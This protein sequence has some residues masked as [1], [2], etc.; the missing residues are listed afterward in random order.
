[1]ALGIKSFLRFSYRLLFDT[2]H[3]RLGWTCRR[4]AVIVGFYLLFPLLELAI[5]LGLLLD[6][7]LFREYQQEPIESPVFIVGNPRSGTTLLHRLLTKDV[8]RFSTMRMWEILLSPSVL[9]RRVVGAFAALD[10]RLGGPLKKRV[11]AL[12]EGWQQQNL[13]HR[14]S[15]WAPEEDDYLLLHI[16][17]ALT[18]GLTSGV[19]E[20]AAR[21][22]RFD[23]ALPKEEREWIMAFYSRCVKRHLY[24][25][26][27]NEGTGRRQYL[28]KNPAFSPKLDT[29]LQHYPDAKIIYLVR[30]PLDMIP[31][32]VSLMEFT[33]GIVGQPVEGDALLTYI[34]DMA[35]HWYTYPLER[36]E[37]AP[38]DSYVVVK[39]DDLVADPEKMVSEIY[40]QLGFEISP[41]F[42]RVLR[43]EAERASRFRSRHHYSLEQM[44][45]AR[46]QIVA[47]YQDVFNR[48]EFDVGARASEDILEC[49]EKRRD[50]RTRATGGRQ[51]RQVEAW[52]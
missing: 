33:W 2:G 22:T 40:G 16:W 8:E 42:A 17:S 5:W 31:S 46:E 49:G 45:L 36:L 20:E 44:G 39:Y 28:A 7:V 18:A 29:A 1:M 10:R 50:R 24:A 34:Q 19:L 12:E 27:R 4:V 9:Q 51:L 13:M 38:E 14:V 26:R 11:R 48:F 15:F 52:E 30:S 43:D 23:T 25:H 6:E 41:R 35:Q 47:E 37:R 32:Y 21:Y 3:L